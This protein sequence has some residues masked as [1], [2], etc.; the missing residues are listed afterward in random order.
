MRLA[1]VQK[2][3]GRPAPP[4]KDVR[5]RELRAGGTDP[6]IVEIA[7]SGHVIWRSIV[8]KGLVQAEANIYICRSK[9]I[10]RRSLL[11]QHFHC[12]FVAR[13]LLYTSQRFT[14]YFHH[15]TCYVYCDIEQVIL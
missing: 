14:I 10:C 13:I 9:P 6:L 3:T 5:K 1:T 12:Y 4:Y 8:K 7:A 11:F 2:P 15:M